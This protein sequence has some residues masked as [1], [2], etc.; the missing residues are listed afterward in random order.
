M[1]SDHGTR[2][3]G[4]NPGG[5][6]ARS[7]SSRAAWGIA[8]Q[9]FS[10]AT[11]FA[12][13]AIVARSVTPEAFGGFALVFATYIIALGVARSV[14]TL[15]LLVRFSG[16][17]DQEWR[18]ATTSA[19]GTALAAGTAGGLVCAVAA[20][21]FPTTATAL[22]AL[23]VTLPLLLLQDTWRH[24]F[25]ARGSP[26][27]AFLNDLG[28]AVFL[29]P[30]LAVPIAI[31]SQSS[32]PFILSWGIAGGAAGLL[33]IAQSRIVPRPLEC[34]RWVRSQWDLGGRQLGEFAAN[35]GST[36]SVMYAA[37][38]IGGLT[39]AGALRGGQVLLN[40]LN[41]AQQG[42]WMVAI[43]EQVR[44]LKKHPWMLE[45]VAAFL[46]LGLGTM[47][48]MYTFGLVAFGDTVGPLLLGETWPNAQPVVVPLGLAAV[49]TGLW[50]GPTVTLRAMQE[51]KRSLRVRLV[52]SV[53]IVAAGTA[54]LALAGARGGAWGIAIAG[55][56]SVP[57]W[58][59]QL[60]AAVS[61]R[62][63]VAV[64]PLRPIEVVAGEEIAADEEVV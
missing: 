36:Q 62:S 48:A 9:A 4:G 10:S 46:S 21:V 12:L 50:V 1:T 44:T 42:I 19:T 32:A 3:P 15:P 58:W 11:N 57:L 34:A 59:W 63:E 33:G 30:A 53:L 29:V 14:N 61:G 52:Y 28:W 25:L 43:P 17:D 31:G 51:A 56:T 60:H 35:T 23:S 2:D 27:S 45:R 39:A 8:D 55:L 16:V 49:A 41:V 40:P 7:V 38:A 20:I 24:A 47:A 18:D 6:T 64:T 13:S 37:G 26:S 22:L 5:R 54:G